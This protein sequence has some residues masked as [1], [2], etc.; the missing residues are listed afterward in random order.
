MNGKPRETYDLTGGGADVLKHKSHTENWPGVNPNQQRKQHFIICIREDT[1]LHVLEP[2]SYCT[3]ASDPVHKYIAVRTAK[4]PRDH[5]WLS[6]ES[7]AATSVLLTTA[8]THPGSPPPSPRLSPDKHW[9][10]RLVWSQRKTCKDEELF[11]TFG[12]TGTSSEG[13]LSNCSH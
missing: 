12:I 5:V 6:A 1:M 4:P 8:T 7:G 3:S 11:F 2:T 10:S 13:I 9:K